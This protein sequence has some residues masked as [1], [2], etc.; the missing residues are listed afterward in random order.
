M[1]PAY[2]KLVGMTGS[3]SSPNQVGSIRIDL[4]LNETEFSMLLHIPQPISPRL[5]YDVASDVWTGSQSIWKML[6]SHFSTSEALPASGHHSRF[7]LLI[8][9][10]LYSDNEDIVLHGAALVL[11]DYNI[12]RPR[13]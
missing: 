9:I 4:S 10:I 6:S 12:H 2:S 5:K 8:K 1:F 13:A 11:S 3:T 7:L